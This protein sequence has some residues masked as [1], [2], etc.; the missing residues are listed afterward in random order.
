MNRFQLTVNKSF[1]IL[2]Y[3]L[4]VLSLLTGMYITVISMFAAIVFA[5]ASIYLVLSV[6]EHRKVVFYKQGIFYHDLFGNGKYVPLE[7]VHL[8]TVTPYLGVRVTRVDLT[9]RKLWFFAFG[10]DREQVNYL[11]SIGYNF[12]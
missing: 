7:A 6:L 8:I 5:I 4:C 11:K 3:T 10:A 12:C 9:E 2:I 1:F